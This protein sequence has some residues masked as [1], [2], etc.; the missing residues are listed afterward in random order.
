MERLPSVLTLDRVRV[1]ELVYRP[2]ARALGITAFGINAYTGDAPGDV[3][4]ECHDE[5]G[6][7]SGR[8][9]ELYV[10]MTGRAEF[11]LDGE[12]HDAPPGTLVFARPEQRR[13]ATALEPDTTILVIGGKPGA[14]GPPSPF[15]YWYRAEPAYRAGDYEQA[16][17]IASEGLEHHP[18]NS[19]LHYQ[20]GCFAALGGRRELALEHLERAFAIAPETREWAKTDDDLASLHL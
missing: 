1:G 5:L 20:L 3:V 2:I 7:G 18:D 19:R 11:E 16:Y 8:H 10:V 12:R 9:E 17:A 6:E 15:E 13:G 4:I 14:A